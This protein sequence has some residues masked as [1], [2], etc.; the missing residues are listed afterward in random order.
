MT[1]PSYSR[2]QTLA[3]YCKNHK[4]DVEMLSCIDKYVDANA[5][6]DRNSACFRCLQGQKARLDFATS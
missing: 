3:V 2:R 1:R 5:I 4:R 6:P